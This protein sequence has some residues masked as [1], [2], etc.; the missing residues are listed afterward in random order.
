MNGQQIID[1]CHD[2][3]KRQ[4]PEDGAP[5]GRA[6]CEVDLLRTKVLELAKR[7]ADAQRDAKEDARGAAVEAHWQERQGEE[8]GNW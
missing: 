2:L 8:Y 7:I 5:M 4:F 6:L 1:N 3:A